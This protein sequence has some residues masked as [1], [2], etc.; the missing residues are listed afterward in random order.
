MLLCIKSQKL[1]TKGANVHNSTHFI[2]NCATAEVCNDIWCIR[3][4]TR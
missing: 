2:L 3:Y 1:P 4:A